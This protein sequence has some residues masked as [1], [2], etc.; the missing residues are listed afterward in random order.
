MHYEIVYSPGKGPHAPQT[1]MPHVVDYE[2]GTDVSEHPRTYATKTLPLYPCV[3]GYAPTYIKVRR[4]GV[5]RPRRRLSGRKGLSV[6]VVIGILCISSRRGR[7]YG[8]AKNEEDTNE[9]DKDFAEHCDVGFGV[10]Q[11]KV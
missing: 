11:E 4:P 5:R 10:R 2:S 3:P 7:Y 1:A 9:L 8:D 6:T